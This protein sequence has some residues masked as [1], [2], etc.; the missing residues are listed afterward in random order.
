VCVPMA[1]A[2][3]DELAVL[4]SWP[5]RRRGLRVGPPEL[6]GAC[7][8]HVVDSKAIGAVVEAWRETEERGAKRRR[9]RERDE[10][11]NRVPLHAVLELVVCLVYLSHFEI[12]N[13]DVLLEIQYGGYGYIVH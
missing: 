13:C 6:A 3:S 4:S 12:L 2:R 9:W 11:G 7:W 5:P 10:G 8:A 1:R